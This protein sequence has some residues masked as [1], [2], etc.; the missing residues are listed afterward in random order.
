MPPDPPRV[1]DCR[2]AMFSILANNFAPLPLKIE[3][4]MYGPSTMVVVEQ[5]LEF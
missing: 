3:K 5:S 1:K 2:V 4:V